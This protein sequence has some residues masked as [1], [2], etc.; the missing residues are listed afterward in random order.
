MRNIFAKVNIVFIITIFLLIFAGV[1]TY[2][3]RADENGSLFE[4]YDDSTQNIYTNDLRQGAIDLYNFGKEISDFNG[5]RPS[6]QP[7][8]QET[9]QNPDIPENYDPNDPSDPQ[10]TQN[11]SNNSNLTMYRQADYTQNL[12]GGCTIAYAGCG[13]VS[14]ANIITYLKGTKV[15]PVDVANKYIAGHASIYANCLGSTPF[16]AAYVLSLP[17]Y[18]FNTEVIFAGKHLTI[19][20]AAEQLLEFV[21]RGSVIHAGGQFYFYDG[22]GDYQENGHFFTIIDIT[23]LANG[24]YDFIGLET[25]YGDRNTIPVSYRTLGRLLYV[26]HAVAVSR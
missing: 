12:P 17:E 6:P 1:L 21:D 3:I 20:E 16:G 10:I 4:E 13:P 15:N 24:D 23:K 22:N 5:T 19:N 11:P 2:S 14:A 18:G 7:T 25:A 26:K 9:T 8:D